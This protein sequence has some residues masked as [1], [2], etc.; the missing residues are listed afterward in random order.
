MAPPS[1]LEM[2]LLAISDELLLYLLSFCGLKD[3]FNLK[4]T[5]TIVQGVVLHYQTLVWNADRFFRPWFRDGTAEFRL[6]LRRSSAIVSGSQ[7]VQFFDRAHYPGS[8]MDI[9]LRLGGVLPMGTW[10]QTQG[11]SRIADS[12][13]YDLAKRVARTACNMI[14]RTQSGHTPVCAV[15]DYHRFVCSETVI[16]RQK[17]QL[18]AVDIDPVQHVLYDFHSTAVMNYMTDEQVV[19]VFPL[20][21]FILRKSYLARSRKEGHDR[22]SKWKNKYQQR[23]FRVVHKR[24]RGSHNDLKQGKRTSM[25]R[26]S[27]T[28]TLEGVPRSQTMYGPIVPNVRFEVMHWR[29]GVAYSDSFVR[30]AEPGI[31]RCL[32]RV[33]KRYPGLLDGNVGRT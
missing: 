25:D 20:S 31:W 33:R 28:I 23:G 19:S 8:D 21:T 12:T 15:I 16:Y 10:L 18:V 7:L 11:Y 13:D 22:S 30:V 29:T 17:I 3:V 6:A 1:A 32:S 27:W 26:Y 2:V 4:A 9:F 24:S 5:S 14:S